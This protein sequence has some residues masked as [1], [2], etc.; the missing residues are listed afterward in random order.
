MG[1]GKT[2]RGGQK[3]EEADCGPADW[4]PDCLKKTSRLTGNK[5]NH[6]QNKRLGI[7]TINPSIARGK[8]SGYRSYPR[9]DTIFLKAYGF[10]PQWLNIA[11]LNITF[12]TF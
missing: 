5:K 7:Q 4:L 11:R 6:R 12:G 2:A 10:G 9:A 8:R 3:G 1:G